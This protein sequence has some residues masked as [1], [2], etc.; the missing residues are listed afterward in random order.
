MS[1]PLKAKAG[2]GEQALISRGKEGGLVARKREEGKWTH[3]NKKQ[4]KR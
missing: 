2:R 1:T 4:R 3:C